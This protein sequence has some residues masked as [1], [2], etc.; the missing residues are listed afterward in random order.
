MVF[1]LKMIITVKKSYYAMA[2]EGKRVQND[3]INGDLPIIQNRMKNHLSYILF[4]S[5]PEDQLYSKA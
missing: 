4:N 5:I 2:V 1:V 3:N